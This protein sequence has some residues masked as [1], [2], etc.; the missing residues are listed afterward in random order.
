V[1][2]RSSVV[3][4]DTEMGRIFG[5]GQVFLGRLLPG[6]VAAGWDVSL[7]V[8]GRALPPAAREL[9]DRLQAAGVEVA[10]QVW[11]QPSTVAGGARRLAAWVRRRSPAAYVISASSGIG[12]AALPHLT[13]PA[14]AIAHSDHET[15]YR[16]MTHYARFLTS[17]VAVSVPIEAEL[18]GRLPDTGVALVP[19]GVP[20]AP[21][22]P[23]KAHHGEQALNVAYVGR[24]SQPLKRFDDV[25]E[26]AAR[27]AG[28]KVH[29]ALVGDGDRRPYAEGRLHRHLAAG[30][31]EMPGWQDE[32]A[33]ARHLEH[34]DA[35]VFSSEV[36]GLPL[37]LLEAMGQAAV[38]V[39]TDISAFRDAFAG[40]Q[41]G[42]TCAVGDVDGFVAALQGLCQDPCK[43][44]QYQLDAWQRATEFS[45]D[46]MVKAYDSVLDGAIHHPH[47]WDPDA[48]FPL[49][50]TCRPRYP[51]P[52]PQA[53]ALALRARLGLR[54]HV[55]GRPAAAANA[56]VA[57]GP[58]MAHRALGW[59]ARLPPA[60]PLLGI[61]RPV[62]VDVDAWAQR[63]RLTIDPVQEPGGPLVIGEEPATVVI[64]GAVA[65]APP[66]VRVQ[67]DIER[68]QRFQGLRVARVPRARLAGHVVVTED[69]YVLRDSVATLSEAVVRP[70]RKD[71]AVLPGAH[72]LLAAPWSVGYC[73]W[74]LDLLPRLRGW[75]LLGGNLPLLLAGN[76]LA[77]W[78]HQSLAAVLG[79]DAELRFYG[80]GCRVESLFLA[81]ASGT[82]GAVDPAA[83]T[84]WRRQAT[85]LMSPQPAG[86]RLYVSRAVA[87]K[88]R[89]TNETDVTAMVA[90]LGFDVLRAE[91][92][93]FADQ[94]RVFSEASVIVGLHGAGLT[95]ALFAPAGATLIEIVNPA[96]PQATYYQLADAVGLGYRVVVGAAGPGGAHPGHADLTVDTAALAAAIRSS[97]K[98]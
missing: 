76:G 51:A 14:V 5:G 42:L 61:P 98:L 39:T 15:F 29:F 41:P 16:P 72:F 13:L 9:T 43:R 96:Y 33:V 4:V 71:E 8:E 73:H 85:P 75:E 19:Y 92:L 23:G 48:H 66:A 44:A 17:A 68:A 30:S 64:R 70:G 26:M 56:D 52:L 90:E 49:M 50:D 84:W 12:W 45:V 36:E 63:R 20:V 53:K 89:V 55:V 40:G 37:A 10:G 79:G 11:P 3:F 80:S 78:Q 6:L 91:E 24:F 87:P 28:P 58:S 18:R 31:V 94:V 88:R 21:E 47:R 46:A 95:N 81:T 67:F 22:P 93:S 69:G 60:W 62:P 83:V 27:L 77:S 32:A 35:I 82:P 57:V 65:A 7:V 25:V 1:S 86:R 97:G 59:A 34:A 2:A 74:I 54:E 38:P